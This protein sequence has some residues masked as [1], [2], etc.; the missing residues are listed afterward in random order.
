M[1]KDIFGNVQEIVRSEVRLAK[2]ELREEVAKSKHAAAWLGVGA[3]GALFAL[4][5]LL[6]SLFFALLYLVPEWAAALL[7]AIMLAVICG[8]AFS[9]GTG[10]LKKIKQIRSSASATQ[11]KENVEWAKQQVK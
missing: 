6:L 8:V 5:F 11:L 10:H 7:I 3:L 9:A 2:T 1:L 4:A